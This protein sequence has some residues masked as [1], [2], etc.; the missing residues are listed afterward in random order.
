MAEPPCTPTLRSRRSP[1]R[2]DAPE[3][4]ARA[5]RDV[6]LDERREVGR[7]GARDAGDGDRRPRG[8]RG[9]A[10]GVD[11]L[12]L[13]RRRLDAA[14]RHT[15][16]GVAA[17]GAAELAVADPGGRREVG[18]HVREKP[19]RP[20]DATRRKTGERVVGDDAVDVR[21]GVTA[22]CSRDPELAG[23]GA[24]AG[25]RVHVA[26]EVKGHRAVQRRVGACRRARVRRA[27][28]GERIPV[29][30]DAVGGAEVGDGGR[31]EGRRD[32]LDRVRPRRVRNRE[33]RADQSGGTD[34]EQ[35][36]AFHGW[37]PSTGVRGRVQPDETSSASRPTVRPRSGL[38]KRCEKKGG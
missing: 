21:V 19:R 10:D 5:D 31:G 1:V 30:A 6:R 34:D 20:V 9:I 17:G 26:G 22:R 7:N 15:L 38:R 25:R 27:G 32:A 3:A 29:G 35:D 13:R 36:D 14:S 4:D 33:A 23:H 2:D 18:R 28:E 16:D 8:C 37:L 24:V 11:P 12:G